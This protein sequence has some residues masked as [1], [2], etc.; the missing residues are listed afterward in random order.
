MIYKMT[1]TNYPVFISEEQLSPEFEKVQVCGVNRKLNRRKNED[2]LAPKK[3]LI[4]S[5]NLSNS[6]RSK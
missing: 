1:E 6:L 2:K 3:V 5:K 4:K